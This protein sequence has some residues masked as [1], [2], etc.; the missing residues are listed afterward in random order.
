MNITRTLL[1]V[2]CLAVL[3]P[4]TAQ[5]K[6]APVAQTRTASD[7]AQL[8]FD[9]AR[10]VYEMR[11]ADGVAMLALW[12]PPTTAPVRGVFINGNP[13]GIGG[14]N[15]RFITDRTFRAYGSRMGFALMGLH[16]MPGN[17]IRERLGARI[18]QALREFAEFGVHPELANIPFASLGNSNGA[19]TSYNLVMHAPE[20]AACFAMNVGGMSQVPPDAALEVPGFIVI[21]PKDGGLP[22]PGQPPRTEAERVGRVRDQVAQARKRGA[23]WAWLAEQNKGHEVGHIF[24][25]QMVFFERCIAARLPALGDPAGDP[26]KGP[27][28][29]RSLPL[30]SGWLVDDLAWQSGLTPIAAFKDFKGDRTI[31]GWVPDEHLAILYRGL[32]TYDSPIRVRFT[33]LGEIRNENDSGRFLT[34]V[35]GHVVAPRTPVTIDVDLTGFPGWQH[36]DV[37]RGTEVVASFDRSTAAGDHVTT[38]VRPDLS[39][40]AF[41]YTVVARDGGGKLRTAI[42]THLVV[43]DPKHPG[44]AA[45]PEIPVLAKGPVAGIKT[46][47]DAAPVKTAARFEAAALSPVDEKKFRFGDDRI[48]EVWASLADRAPTLVLSPDGDKVE[49]TAFA[50]GG[51]D[52]TVRV[53]AAHGKAGLY[54]LFEL[55]DDVATD[56]T[57]NDDLNGQDAV[58]LLLTS[59]PPAALW[60][61]PRG[62]SFVNAGWS[63]TLD[64][65]EIQSPF[66][67]AK[68]P[69]HV[70]FGWS[71]PWEWKAV[72][73]PRA[74]LAKKRGIR[75]DVSAPQK[76][77]VQ[78]WF[79]PWSAVGMGGVSAPPT[80]GTTL[81]FSL[82][83]NDQDP[84]GTPQGAR[85]SE[86]L[87]LRGK[88]PWALDS[89]KGPNEAWGELVLLPPAG[90]APAAS[91]P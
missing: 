17:T 30:E 41:A 89:Q 78:E 2:G 27:V 70:R 76:A 77:R 91:R 19:G 25:Y 10:N 42:P 9:P 62:E 38:T 46:A 84:D 45:L 74:A 57:D 90:A 58:A 39:A 18:F 67:A 48:S 36:L 72:V 33:N 16:S 28:K 14:D 73:L 53:R 52:A 47:A 7:G 88:S 65:A 63:I 31:A 20:R 13:G 61:G 3:G 49:A 12:V 24:D 26:R 8:R 21:G 23:R 54:F 22:R 34:E 44:T 55:Q 5:A 29:L 69:R 51:A 4:V 68:T 64:T 86:R 1:M 6:I 37:V 81:A 11:A 50:A 60:A 75:I 40:I 79:V 35:G 59:R 83:F 85:R 87:R 32:A 80:P 82:G 66:G 43:E 56:A 71:D 15:R